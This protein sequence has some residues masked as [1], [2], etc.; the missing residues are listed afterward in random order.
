[1]KFHLSLSTLTSL[2]TSASLSLFAT[3]TLPKTVQGAGHIMP[4]EYDVILVG[5]GVGGCVMAQSIMDLDG[6]KEV[7]IIERGLEPG[8]ETKNI[9]DIAIVNFDPCIEKY[10]STDGMLIGTG[11]CF[12]GATMMNTGVWVEEHPEWILERIAEL[13]D[14]PFFNASEIQEAID[15]VRDVVMPT[16]QIEPDGSVLDEVVNQLFNASASLGYGP[17]PLNE[18]PGSSVY[19]EDTS[20]RG[21]SIF[22]NVTGDRRAAGDILNRNHP[23]LTVMLNTTVD[24]VIFDNTTATCVAIVGGEDICVKSGG[25]IYLTA[26]PFHTPEL[27]I[28]SGIGPG[29][30]LV[31]NAE[32]STITVCCNDIPPSMHSHTNTSL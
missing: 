26:G 18:L 8:P 9:V 12:G 30:E 11:N 3:T 13:T 6:T 24:K 19:L 4:K 22:N 5:G 15:W 23:K 20:F 25:R 17:N 28:K 14:E 29:G 16:A 7:L 2:W 32:A 27:L 10:V 21:F 1:M 31:D